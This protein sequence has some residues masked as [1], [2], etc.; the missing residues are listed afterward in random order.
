MIRKA[1][2]LRHPAILAA[3]VLLGGCQSP[4][5]AKLFPARPQPPPVPA[6]A[7]APPPAPEAAVQAGDGAA[8]ASDPVLLPRKRSPHRW[9]RQAQAPTA[10]NA[11]AIPTRTPEAREIFRAAETPAVSPPLPTHEGVPRSPD[12]EQQ[13]ARPVGEGPILIQPGAAAQPPVPDPPS[14]RTPA[15]T[16]TGA[17]PAS[18]DPLAPARPAALAPV[19]KALPGSDTTPY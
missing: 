18:L 7:V 4:F 12:Q 13:A 1:C 10:R 3:L 8:T 5:F 2:Q 9:A 15:G 19:H 6:V 16:Q 14:P 11:G 17:K